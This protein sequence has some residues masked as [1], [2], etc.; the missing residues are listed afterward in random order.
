MAGVLAWFM[1]AMV[2]YP[3]VQS[4]AQKELDEII[5]RDRLPS[6]ADY[7]QLHFIRATLKEVLRWHPIDPL[8]KVYYDRLHVE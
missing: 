1:L 3:D 4:M 8:G 7:E 5:G 2:M 6:F